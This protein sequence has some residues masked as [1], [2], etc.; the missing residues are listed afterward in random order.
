M[1]FEALQEEWYQTHASNLQLDG[2][3]SVPTCH[4]RQGLQVAVGMLFPESCD[5]QIDVK[6]FFGSK[7]MNQL[8][9]VI[10]PL[11]MISLWN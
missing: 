7:D 1:A 4:G 5:F 8:K 2:P 10:S 3:L 9:G 6:Y 11:S